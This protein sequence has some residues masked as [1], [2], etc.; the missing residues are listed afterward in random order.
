MPPI[1]TYNVITPN[2]DGKNDLFI[3]KGIEYY[4]NSLLY[5]YNRWGQ[6]VKEFEG[7]KNNW[8]YGGDNDTLS[9]GVYYY[10]LLL[11]DS[12]AKKNAYKGPLSVIK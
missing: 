8:P 2:D 7:Y 5:I 6:K 1:T 9:S 3:I 10:V 4:P 11:R 12:R